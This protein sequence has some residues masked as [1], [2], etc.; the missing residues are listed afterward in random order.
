MLLSR[1]VEILSRLR[2][3]ED[4]RTGKSLPSGSPAHDPDVVRALYTVLAEV[5]D[6]GEGPSPEPAEA[7]APKRPSPTRAGKPWTDDEDKCLATG[8]DEGRTV[9]ELSRVLERSQAAVRLRLVKLGRLSAEDAMTGRSRG[10]P[11]TVP[12]G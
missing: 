9:G 12:A 5:T 4:P 10:V 11:E 1:A 2:D 3:G 8:F 7:P 6:C